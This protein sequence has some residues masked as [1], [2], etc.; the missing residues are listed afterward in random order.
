MIRGYNACEAAV[1]RKTFN[2]LHYTWYH[3]PSVHTKRVHFS[4]LVLPCINDSC[5]LFSPMKKFSYSKQKQ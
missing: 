1:N 4:K 2:D 3:L 5:I